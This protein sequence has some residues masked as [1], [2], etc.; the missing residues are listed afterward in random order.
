MTES[1]AKERAR[2]LRPRG[3]VQHGGA[4]RV[5][6]IPSG[7]ENLAINSHVAVEDDDRVGRGVAMWSSSRAGS[8]WNDVVL[9]AG[10]LVLMEQ[11]QLERP[12]VRGLL[13]GAE[14]DRGQVC[15]NDGFSHASILSQM[16]PRFDRECI[17]LPGVEKRVITVEVAA[18]GIPHVREDA[19]FPRRPRPA[20]W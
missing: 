18:R 16:R 19:D 20:P 14:R 6:G 5:M 8:I 9:S 15:M 17:K 7:P 12:V 4:T 10:A 11:L 3:L 2:V 1:E 13:R